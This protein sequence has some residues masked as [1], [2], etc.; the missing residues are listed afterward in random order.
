MLKAIAKSDK[1]R[2]SS[3]F[4]HL[5]RGQ[6]VFGEKVQFTFKGKKSYQTL[7]GA[8]ASIIFKLILAFFIA[9]EFYVIFAKKQPAIGI[10]EWIID[11]N[12]SIKPF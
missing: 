3:C 11:E 9:Y 2:C 12:M 10:K 8:V 1:G 5:I 7:I 6:D 4:I